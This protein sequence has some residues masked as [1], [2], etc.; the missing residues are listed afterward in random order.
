MPASFFFDNMEHTA[1]YAKQNHPEETERTIRK[2]DEYLSGSYLFDGRWDLERNAVPFQY[3]D[4]KDYLRQDGED[5]EAVY[6]F[7]RMRQWLTLAEAYAL[8]KDERYTQLF[9]TQMTEWIITIRRDDPKAAKAWRTLE[10]GFRME[11][12]SKAYEIFKYSPLFTKTDEKLFVSSMEEHANYLINSWNDYLLI[13]NWGVIINHGLFTASQLLPETEKTRTWERISLNHLEKELSLQIADDGIHWEQSS[14]YHDEVLNALLDVVLLL[15]HKKAPV[16]KALL[17]KTK[18]AAHACAAMQKPNGHAIQDGDSDDIDQSDLVTLSSLLFDDPLLSAKANR[19]IDYDRIWLVTDT[20][21]DTYRKMDGAIPLLSLFPDSRHAVYEKEG[22]FLHFKAGT[23]GAGHGHADQLHIDL[24]ANGE[25]LLVDP[26]RYTYVPGEERYVMKRSEAHNRPTVKGLDDYHIKDSWAYGRMGKAY[27]MRGKEK[28][29]AV[30]LSALNLGY[31]E[32][33]ITIER[34]IVIPH[35]GLVILI[36]TF[37]GKGDFTAQNHFHFSGKGILSENGATF[38]TEKNVMYLSFSDGVTLSKGKGWVSRH[39]NERK[40]ADMLT[41]GKSGSGIVSLWTVIQIG[42]KE[43]TSFLPVTSNCRG[44]AFPS[45]AIEA[46]K[47]GGTIVAAA[48]KE[49]ASPTD[50]F[51][52]GG[53]TGWGACVLF[54]EDGPEN[55]TI[56]EY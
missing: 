50:L 43:K 37:T 21:R 15:R 31:G 23:L 18:K 14:M 38:T 33:G 22:M 45:S 29:G 36:D 55:G 46:M 32:D 7:N 2:A 10:A 3:E 30:Y 47:A 6:A 1:A 48:H 17:E 49:W 28:D 16:P 52:A 27:G 20:E 39:Y 19:Q 9:L 8:T 56:L 5:S 13:S 35:P 40:Q 12:W 26:G 41:V 42:S 51:H 54:T 24:Y 44:T 53:K 25:E 11:Y 4:I 34:R